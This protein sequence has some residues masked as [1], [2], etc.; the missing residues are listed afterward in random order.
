MN[1]LEL[2]RGQR[3]AGLDAALQLQQLDLKI[4][5]GAEVRMVVLEAPQLGD[6]S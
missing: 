3:Y 2:D 5:S 4:D 1:R 6:L